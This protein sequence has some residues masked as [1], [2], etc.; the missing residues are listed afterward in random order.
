[1]VDPL[2]IALAAAG[3][4]I[5]GL[6]KGAAGMGF[7]TTALPLLVLSLGVETAM[8]LVLIPSLSSNVFVMIEA[9]EFRAMV[10]RF[11][12]MLLCLVPGLCLG[13]WC[14]AVVD[15]ASA[16]AV[17]GLVLVVYGIY[18]LTQPAI[19]LPPHLE[20]P[21]QPPVGLLN[22]FVNGLTGSQIFPLPPFLLTLDLKS[23]QF[24]QTN[25]IA[26]TLS[27]LIMMAGLTQIG[28]M[29]KAIFVLSV[30]G[31]VPTYIGVMLGGKVRARLDVETF[32]KLVLLV[33]MALGLVLVVRWMV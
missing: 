24:T 29:T 6:V 14:L 8:P 7:S 15:K 12:L 5:A 4:F 9:G 20:R 32:R 23:N 19:K 16:A 25:N 2:H 33:L 21:L 17:L 3:L 31:I 27:S 13:L 30:F 1:M 10:S 18:A 11:W 22:G 26:F 28:F